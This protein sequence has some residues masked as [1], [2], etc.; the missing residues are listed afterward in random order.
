MS[1]KGSGMKNLLITLI[2]VLASIQFSTAQESTT[3]IQKIDWE[4]IQVVH[5]QEAVEG[6]IKGERLT[7]TLKT[8]LN[9]GTKSKFERV[10][11]KKLKQQAAEKGYSYIYL[12]EDAYSSKRFNKRGIKITIVA[13]G[14]KS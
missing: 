7:E 6:L 5:E 3:E 10:C 12:D 2:I 14:Y 8:S 9:F 1:T 13:R 4:H 11:L